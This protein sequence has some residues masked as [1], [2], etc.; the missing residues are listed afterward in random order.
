MGG[1]WYKNACIASK[2][3][4]L[5]IPGD[6]NQHPLDM[7]VESS[8]APTTSGSSSNIDEEEEEEEE[9]PAPMETEPAEET[10]KP[11]PGTKNINALYTLEGAIL[12]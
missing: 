8:G 2:I 3:A 7:A 6:V 4:S 5:F 9:I 1:P 10:P 12:I 11:Q